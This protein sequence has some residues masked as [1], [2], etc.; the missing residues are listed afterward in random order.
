MVRLAGSRR[1][2]LRRAQVR[3]VQADGRAMTPM[4]NVTIP[5][6]MPTTHMPTVSRL[7]HGGAVPAASSPIFCA[8]RL[9]VSR[10]SPESEWDP[11]TGVFR[12]GAPVA[13]RCSY[14]NFAEPASAAL[15]HDQALGLRDW[16]LVS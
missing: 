13:S 4:D 8:E 9:A 15:T 1:P 3:V 16:R 6:A 10:P 14:G 11:R 5:I 7:R 2:L 12:A